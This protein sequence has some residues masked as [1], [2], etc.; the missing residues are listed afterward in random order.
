M[1][2]NSDGAYIKPKILEVSELEKP[3][4]IHHLRIQ[5]SVLS[6]VCLWKGDS[7]CGHTPEQYRGT[8]KSDCQTTSIKTQRTNVGGYYC[9]W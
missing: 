8:I 6:D 7:L 1:F 2:L 3:Y 4:C 5:I 9:Q